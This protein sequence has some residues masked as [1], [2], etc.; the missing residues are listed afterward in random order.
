MKMRFKIASFFVIL[1]LFLVTFKDKDTDLIELI[2]QEFQTTPT[3]SG[4]AKFDLLDATQFTDLMYPWLGFPVTVLSEEQLLGGGD[5]TGIPPD[6]LKVK[7]ALSK[8]KDKKRRW[9]DWR[10]RFKWKI[11]DY[12]SSWS[13]LRQHLSQ[14][15]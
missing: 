9:Y 10:S 5:H 12:C 4:R 11:K 15:C 7:K 13:R 3:S 2:N 1:L 6:E 8:F 14:I